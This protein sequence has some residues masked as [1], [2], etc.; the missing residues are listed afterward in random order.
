MPQG[1]DLPDEVRDPG[2]VSWAAGALD[3]VM[4]HHSQM[5]P[6]TERIEQLLAAISAWDTRRDDTR[7]IAVYQLLRGDGMAAIS[8]GLGDRLASTSTSSPGLKTLRTLGR[9]LVAHAAHREPLKLGIT[10]L[11][12]AGEASDVP[13]M[14]LLGRHEEFTLYCA[15]A[16]TRLCDDWVLEFWALAKHVHGW[17]RIHLVERL[18]AQRDPRLKDW[19]VRAGFRNA[20]MDEYLACICAEAGDMH[21]LLA[22]LVIDDELLDALGWLIAALINGGPAGDIDDYAHAP[23]ALADYLRHLTSRGQASL[24][25]LLTIDAISAWMRVDDDT[26]Y[27]RYARGWSLK[28]ALL[29]R[30][31][32]ASLLEHISW[33]YLALVDVDSPDHQRSWVALRALDILGVD[34]FEVHLRRLRQQPQQSSRWG[35]LMSHCPANRVDEVLSLAEEIIP[36]DAISS[37][38]DAAARALL[39]TGW[40]ACLGSVLQ[41]LHRFPGH[42]WRLIAT[43]LRSPALRNRHHALAA[44]A[45]WD[46]SAWPADALVE[47]EAAMRRERD[48]KARLHLGRIL[49]GKD[50]QP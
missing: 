31:R 6:E 30:Q 17:G 27:A 1:E 50:P 46:R 48:E 39:P 25:H 18:C 7:M 9:W 19:L 49:A 26:W 5:T 41:E 29:C 13:D 35:Q 20:V 22:Q 33:P 2:K 42:G 3:G 37:P 45:A 14:H 4:S 47:L 32:V 10:L 8:D 12:L 43:G 11:G 15:V 23:A 44:I 38:D 24:H 36:L 21:L 34:T 28:M 40:H 16:L